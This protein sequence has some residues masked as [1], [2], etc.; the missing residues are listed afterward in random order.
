M[1]SIVAID[2]D[3]VQVKYCKC[4]LNE[5]QTNLPPE[6]PKCPEN[7]VTVSTTI[8]SMLLGVPRA[9]IV[10]GIF[11]CG[12]ELNLKAEGRLET[13]PYTAS[14]LNPKNP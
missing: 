6:S 13:K 14:A 5:V 12:V 7:G 9:R 4:P 8:V 1:T 2:A 10:W 3:L 11:P